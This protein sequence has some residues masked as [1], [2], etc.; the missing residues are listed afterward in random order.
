M[1]TTDTAEVTDCGF[2]RDGQP[3]EL[4]TLAEVAM[5]LRCSKAHLCNV[6][7]GKVTSLQPL[8]HVALGRRKLIRRAAL[9]AWLDRV[10][11]CL[12]GR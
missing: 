10:E 3:S 12:E 2:T 5:I 7:N 11:E 6:L 9:E 4:L 8:P 1:K